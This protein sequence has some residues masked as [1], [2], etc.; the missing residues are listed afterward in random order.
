MRLLRFT[1]HT[2]S[3]ITTLY[4]G[5]MFDEIGHTGTIFLS[6]TKKFVEEYGANIFRCEV[7][8]GRVFDSTKLPFIEELYR[9]GFKLS[10][11]DFN[12][13]GE[14]G[15][16]PDQECY[17]YAERCWNTPRDFLRWQ[18]RNTWQSIEERVVLAYI[19]ARYDSILLTEQQLE[20]DYRSATNYY[21]TTDRVRSKQLIGVLSQ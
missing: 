17:N 9:A 4:H 5:S 13:D 14:S 15:G 6:K 10:N 7:D 16:D 11:Q 8:L 2:E 20:L 12:D 1:E 19:M 21:T 3:N 18:K